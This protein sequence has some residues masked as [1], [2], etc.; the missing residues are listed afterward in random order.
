MGYLF[1][2]SYDYVD[3]KR[4]QRQSVRTY[5]DVTESVGYKSYDARSTFT[6]NNQTDASRTVEDDNAFEDQRSATGGYMQVKPQDT[7]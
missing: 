5:G 6:R 2:A 4:R 7:N 3:D 1:S